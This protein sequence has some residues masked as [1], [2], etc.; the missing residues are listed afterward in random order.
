MLHTVLCLLLGYANPCH[1]APPDAATPQE[2]VHSVDASGPAG[3][4]APKVAWLPLPAGA[5]LYAYCGGDPINRSDMSGLD[6][7]WN[8]GSWEY[9]PD[10]DPFV[11]Y[12][13]FNP[14]TNS[15]MPRYVDAQTYVGM[16]REREV[17]AIDVGVG[18]PC[19]CLYATG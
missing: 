11:P 14:D 9:A 10:T 15:G 2:V 8:S 16:R 12:P 18:R 19:C 5:R 4:S 1:A 7:R 3:Q 6:W 17:V 13:K